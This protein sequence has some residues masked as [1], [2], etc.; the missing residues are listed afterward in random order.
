MPFQNSCARRQIV[1]DYL[2]GLENETVRLVCYMFTRGY[3]DGI[4]R[5]NLRLSRPRFREIRAEIAQGLLD[6]GIILRGE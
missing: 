4:I 6:A 3:P 1:Q 2:A 5:R